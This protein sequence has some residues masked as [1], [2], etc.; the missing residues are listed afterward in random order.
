M[1]DARPWQYEMA[2]RSSKTAQTDFRTDSPCGTA[3]KT[4]KIEPVSNP[5]EFI[6]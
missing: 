4:D 1:E 3:M 6:R 5:P 2:S